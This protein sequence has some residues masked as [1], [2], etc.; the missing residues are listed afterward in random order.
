MTDLTDSF[1]DDFIGKP[2]IVCPHQFIKCEH[3]FSCG[4]GAFFGCRCEKCYKTKKCTKMGN[5]VYV[6]TN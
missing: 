4:D 6:D 1:V 5:D 3:H 2:L